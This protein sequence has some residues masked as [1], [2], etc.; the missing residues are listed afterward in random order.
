V[1][2]SMIWK[3]DERGVTEEVNEFNGAQ[4]TQTILPPRRWDPDP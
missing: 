3:K 1:K 4:E 2:W